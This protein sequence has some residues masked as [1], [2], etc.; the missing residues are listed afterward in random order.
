[1][2]NLSST[3]DVNNVQRKS[4][5]C[6]VKG[7]DQLA[8][9]QLFC[10]NTTLSWLLHS[11]MESLCGISEFTPPDWMSGNMSVVVS[12]GLSEFVRGVGNVVYID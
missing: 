3:W 5:I 2:F 1:M 10:T 7:I 4:V 11:C 8:D 6:T 9:L 12:F